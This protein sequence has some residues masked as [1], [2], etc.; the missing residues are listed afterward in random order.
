MK[1]ERLIAQRLNV[2]V[3]TDD[4]NAQYHVIERFGN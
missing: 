2:E 4:E 3:K 1:L